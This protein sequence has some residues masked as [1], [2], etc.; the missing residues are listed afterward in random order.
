MLLLDMGCEYYCYDSDITCSFPAN[1][2]F[3]ED[4][5]MVYEAVLAAHEAV[6]KAI[7]P[8]V[9]WPVI[10]HSLICS[11]IRPSVLLLVYSFVC[12]FT[13][14]FPP[15]FLHSFMHAFICLVMVCVLPYGQVCLALSSSLNAVLSWSCG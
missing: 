14:S 15:L 4:Q 6:I 2:K 12:S 13:H 5:A 8:G 11:F 10:L 3:S 9:S 7:K 1:G